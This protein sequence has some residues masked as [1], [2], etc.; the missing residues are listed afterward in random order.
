MTLRYFLLLAHIH[1]TPSFQ[2]GQSSL[3]GTLCG[4]DGESLS[5]VQS[6]CPALQD[7]RV[8]AHHTLFRCLGVVLGVAA[9]GYPPRVVDSLTARHGGASRLQR[10]V[11]ASGG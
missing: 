11:A 2:V 7:A 10:R 3:T 5:H 8:Q 9:V 4:C 6:I 1:A